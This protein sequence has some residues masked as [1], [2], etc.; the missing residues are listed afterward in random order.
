MRESLDEPISVV[1]YYNALLK[2]QIPHTLSWKGHEYR[3]GKID[4]HHKTYSGKTLIHH[5]SL[6]DTASQVYFKIALN[7]D[8]LH[9]T[10]EE[11]MTGDQL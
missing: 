5:F 4:F 9:W 8:N 2:R 1:W 6:C 3:L 7:T 10:L 11:F